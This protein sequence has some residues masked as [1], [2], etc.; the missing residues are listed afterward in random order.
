MFRELQWPA[1]SSLQYGYVQLRVVP[2][3][4]GDIIQRVTLQ[5]LYNEMVERSYIGEQEEDPPL[6]ES[7]WWATAWPATEWEHVLESSVKTRKWFPSAGFVSTY[8]TVTGAMELVARR[9]SLPSRKT[10]CSAFAT[11]LGGFFFLRERL[12]RTET[13]EQVQFFG[14]NGMELGLLYTLNLSG[15]FMRHCKPVHQSQSQNSAIFTSNIL[16]ILWNTNIL[17]YPLYT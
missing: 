7:T 6:Y 13:T 9:I 8:D 2:A 11:T 15:K 12:V 5:S 1:M 17:F 10:T 4:M 16:S 3:Y 14:V